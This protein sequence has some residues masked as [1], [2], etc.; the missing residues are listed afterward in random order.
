MNVRQMDGFEIQNP[1]IFTEEL[2]AWD[3]QGPMNIPGA[4]LI[5]CF[6]TIQAGYSK[7]LLVII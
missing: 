2:M 7:S 4:G 1:K 6:G 3:M 5:V